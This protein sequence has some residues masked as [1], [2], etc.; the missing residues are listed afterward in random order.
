MEAKP[1]PTVILRHTK[2]I[3]PPKE[4]REPRERD[5]QRGR[6]CVTRTLDA[7]RNSLFIGDVEIEV[8]EIRGGQVRLGIYADRSVQI[9]R[10]ERMDKKK[11]M[12]V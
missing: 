8:L 7:P 10:K 1:V 4:I 5:P 12:A 3:K 6:L 9:E 11:A 2:Q